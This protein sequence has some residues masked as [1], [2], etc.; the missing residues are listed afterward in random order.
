MLGIH[1]ALARRYAGN[2]ATPG[3][4]APPNVVVEV[5]ALPAAPK[6]QVDT[7][8]VAGG[9][10]SSEGA[11]VDGIE[12]NSADD[13]TSPARL[14]RRSIDGAPQPAA[15]FSPPKPDVEALPK[16]PGY[17]VLELIGKGAMGRVYRARHLASGRAAAIKTLAP[18]LAVRPDFVQRFEREG[19]AMRAI[20]HPG[21]VQVWDQGRA[22]ADTYYIPMAYIP[23]HPLRK[24]LA[25]GPLP[26]SQAPVSVALAGRG[27]HHWSPAPRARR[28]C[29]SAAVRADVG[30]S[31]VSANGGRWPE[32]CRFSLHPV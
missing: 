10:P 25:K 24:Y 5:A 16:I 13:L 14:S 27:L 32:A 1:P 20:D 26:L 4:I 22:G 29:R 30:L 23:G 17:D 2:V 9:V 6:P 8:V 3:N 7:R 12:R 31:C 21:V 11:V 19:A 18:E 28:R 15:V